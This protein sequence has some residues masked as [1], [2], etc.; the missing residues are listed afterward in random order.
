MM[1]LEFSE[2]GMEEPAVSKKL[3]TLRI[4]NKRLFLS[5]KIPMAGEHKKG[6]KYCSQKVKF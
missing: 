4:K 6:W 1:Y 3:V 2:Q 5:G